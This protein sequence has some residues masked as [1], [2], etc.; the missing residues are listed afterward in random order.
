[1]PRL[2]LPKLVVAFLTRDA[3]TT[4]LDL[5][6]RVSVLEGIAGVKPGTWMRNVVPEKEIVEV[7]GPRVKATWLSPRGVRL[8]VYTFVSVVKLQEV[9]ARTHPLNQAEH[10]DGDDAQVEAPARRH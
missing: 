3:R 10:D 9:H 5:L 1:M 2:S 7:F 4:S 6:A 8:V